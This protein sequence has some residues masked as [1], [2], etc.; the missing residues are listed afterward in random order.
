VT[1][2][3]RHSAFT[4]VELLVVIA[5]V[6]VLIALLLPAVQSAREAARRTQCTSS[7][8][9]LAVAALDFE[10]AEHTLP[11]AGVFL[12]EPEAVTWG[13]GNYFHVDMREGNLQSWVVRL[14]PYIEQRAL[15]REFDFKQH[16][17][18]NAS[19]PQAAQPVSLLCPSDEAPGRMYMYDDSPYDGQPVAF[20]K[21]NYAGFA[22]P[23][24]I[25]GYSYRGAIWLYGVELKEIIDGTTDTL[26][27]GEI[28][29]RAHEQDQRGAW[30]LPWSGSTQ[31]SVDMHYPEYGTTDQAMPSEGYKYDK[32]SFGLTQPPNSKNPDVLYDCPDS[33]EA[34]L[35]AMP[36]NT[37]FTGYIS[38][39]PRSHHPGGVHVAYV[40]GHVSF[41]SNNVDE[42]TMAYQAAINDE[43]FHEAP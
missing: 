3:R 11:P 36:C 24:H 39:A 1:S 16:V 6:G 26:M 41:M 31:L 8:K 12:P 32:V 34:L 9:Q 7:L 19:N 2:W 35:D 20:G 40:D 42:V 28:R 37:Q 22:S 38:A 5:V 14:L 23:F 33:P 18:N 21:A 17:A 15:F 43:E 25:D 30:A 29:T 13:W 27:L 10:A 4:L